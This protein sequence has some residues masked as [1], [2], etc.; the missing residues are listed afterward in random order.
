MYCKSCGTPIERGDAFCGNCG[1][2]ATEPLR[3]Q[4]PTITADDA[5]RIAKAQQ[6]EQGLNT[7]KGGAFFLAILIL[8]GVISAFV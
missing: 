3:N 6:H 1:R 5:Q 7:L 8:A 2:P 4:A